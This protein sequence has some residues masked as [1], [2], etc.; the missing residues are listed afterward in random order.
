MN[1][2][3]CRALEDLRD[4]LAVS[5]RARDGHLDTIYKLREQV[6]RLTAVK[7]VVFGLSIKEIAEKYKVKESTPFQWIFR[8]PDFPSSIPGFL[9]HRYDETDIELWMENH[10]KLGRK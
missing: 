8:Y 3:S 2:E 6:R 1:C 7:G 9:P 4:V 5:E 10:Q